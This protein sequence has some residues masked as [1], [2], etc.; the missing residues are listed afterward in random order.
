MKHR[1][2]FSAILILVM[3]VMMLSGCGSS[4]NTIENIGTYDSGYKA[5]GL[6]EDLSGLNITEHQFKAQTAV[7]LIDECRELIINGD[8]EDGS[9]ALP[10][11]IVLKDCE[12][13]E[14]M[15]IVSVY[16]EGD[17]QSLSSSQKV[18]MKAAIVDVFTQ[19]EGIVSYVRFYMNGE[20]MRDSRGT[21]ASMMRSDFVESTMADIKDIDISQFLIYFAS[22]DNTMLVGEV[23]EIHY[24]NTVSEE[25]VVIDALISGPLKP[26][27]NR[28]LPTDTRVNSVETKDGI[29]Y[30]D[31]DSSFLTQYGDQRFAI[32][33]YAI[34][35]SLC[36]LDNVEGV[37]ILINGETSTYISDGVMLSGVLRKNEDIILKTNDNPPALE[38]DET[39]TEI[40]PSEDGPEQEVGV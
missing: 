10:E 9:S 18:L 4:S 30:V 5:Y 29:C 27:L 11:G 19:F 7:E 23:Y 32:K 26:S 12:Y 8:G 38:T 3:S 2:V 33:V 6:K 37:R 13:N 39:E 20:P 24:Y 22:T 25:R 31:L 15:K 21:G 28:V 17:P 40:P 14:E 36:E 16:L 34:V 35:N 1:K